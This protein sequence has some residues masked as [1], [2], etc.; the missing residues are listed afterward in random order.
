MKTAFT[1]AAGF[2]ALTCVT[3]VVATFVLLGMAVFD[4]EP[5]TSD[6]YRESDYFLLAIVTL[7]AA[8]V[9][10]FSAL[11]ALIAGEDA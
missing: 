7:M 11:L 2:L 9:A 1:I 6:G 8:V 10:G 3:L 5:L 4:T